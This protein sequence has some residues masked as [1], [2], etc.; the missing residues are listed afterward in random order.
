MSRALPLAVLPLLFLA[1]ASVC[2]A[3]PCDYGN[4][5]AEQS[6]FV[7]WKIHRPGDELPAAPLVLYWIPSSADD[8]RHSDLLTSRSLASYVAQCVALEVVTSDDTELLDQLGIEGPRPA[9]V[10]VD[11][12]GVIVG[13]IAG[14]RGVLRAVDVETMVRDGMRAR[15]IALN[16]ALDD[17]PK[18]ISAG[19]R[20]LGVAIYRRV[21]MQRC[22]FP[23]HGREAERALKKLGVALVAETK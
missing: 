2:D 21:W 22:L 16:E 20:D 11:G 9:A 23:R 7:P 12:W 18:K 5:T 17:A 4:G 10:L 13:R 15:E 19:D 14:E 8:F 3:R 1:A 6:A